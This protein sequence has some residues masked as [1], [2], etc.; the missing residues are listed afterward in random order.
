MSLPVPHCGPRPFRFPLLL[1]VG[2]ARVYMWA[3]R[4]RQ[5]PYELVLIHARE[6][7]HVNLTTLPRTNA[8]EYCSTK[9]TV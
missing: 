4:I 9:R 2:L 6:P 8:Y 7:K 5:G 1:Y 3:H